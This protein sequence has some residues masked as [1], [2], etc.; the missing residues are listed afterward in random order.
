VAPPHRSPPHRAAAGD[1]ATGDKATA[2]GPGYLTVTARSWGAVYVDG[3][4]VAA[5][6]PLYRHPLPAGVHRIKVFQ[7]SSGEYSS[8]Q[9]VEVRAGEVAELSFK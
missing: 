8:V 1:Q 4:Q 9:Q 2:T 6:T 5:Q 7:P 3:K